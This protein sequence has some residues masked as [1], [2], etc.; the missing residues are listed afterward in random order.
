MTL[1]LIDEAVHAGARQREACEV[2]E[3]D[4]RTVQR[5]KAQGI[6]EDRRAG[7]RS[8]P[9]NQ[10]SPKERA[11]IVAL[12]C[13]PE[14]RDQSVSQVVPRLADE[15][16]YLASESTMYRVLREEKLAAHRSAARPPTHS[17]PR[18]QVATGPNQLWSWDITYLRSPNRGV[19]F[20]LYM[21]VDVWSRKVVGA[22]VHEVE[23]TDL[24]AA[25]MR[26][27]CAGEGIEPGQVA[28]HADNGGPMKGAT[29]QATL[30]IPQ[31]PACLSTNNSITPQRSSSIR[32]VRHTLHASTVFAYTSIRTGITT[33]SSSH[34]DAN[35]GYLI[36]LHCTRLYSAPPVIPDQRTQA[37]I[38]LSLCLI[39][40]CHTSPA[41]GAP[42]RPTTY[43]VSGLLSRSSF[44]EASN[45]DL[46]CSLNSGH[47][48]RHVWYSHCTHTSTTLA[49]RSVAPTT[50]THSRRA[51]H[52]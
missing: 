48:S 50:T 4:P 46:N 47:R 26:P 43:I 33:P 22:E 9:A 31:S 52:V 10:L 1:G 11:A 3:I 34:K 16:E 15:G 5:W 42:R 23:S 24:A 32:T 21:V 12:L 30:E 39:A 20:Y 29:L 17:R 41:A 45:S 13:S 35:I 6:G 44:S 14:F 37:R 28:L 40:F 8:A 51:I 7:P 49:T 2:L 18:E 19:F 36:R 25:L 38:M 27:V